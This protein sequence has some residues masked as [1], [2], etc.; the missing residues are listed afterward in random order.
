MLFTY[1]LLTSITYNKGL[2][3]KNN[4]KTLFVSLVKDLTV[5]YLPIVFIAQHFAF[6][7]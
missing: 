4:S 6:I 3:I 7:A 2:G 5:S 1:I